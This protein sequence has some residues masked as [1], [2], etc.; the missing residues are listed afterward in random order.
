MEP[1]EQFLLKQVRDRVAPLKVQEWSTFVE[2]LCLGLLIFGILACVIAQFI[3][4]F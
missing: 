2:M 1:H 4:F 3:F